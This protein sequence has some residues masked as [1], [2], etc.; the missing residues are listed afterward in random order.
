MVV[1]ATSSFFE[2][3]RGQLSI[4]CA[5]PDIGTDE[6]TIG[7]LRDGRVR[8]MIAVPE[9]AKL[10]EFDL[11]AGIYDWERAS[12]GL[13]TSLEWQT[14]LEIVDAISHE[15][16][17]QTLKKNELE[18]WLKNSTVCQKRPVA[19]SFITWRMCSTS[20]HDRTTR[21]VLR[22]VWMRPASS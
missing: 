13:G 6:I 15:T 5:H 16:V 20:T 11:V 7:S 17:R 10:G 9:D 18:L 4:A 3:G 2:S 22:C 14:R 12:G 1:N 19:S 8:V 21:V